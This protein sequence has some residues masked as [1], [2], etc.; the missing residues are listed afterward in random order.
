MSM[1]DTVVQFY[2]KFDYSTIFF[3][4]YVGS[5]PLCPYI[6]LSV[7]PPYFWLI[8]MCFYEAGQGQGQDRLV[9]GRLGTV[10]HVFSLR[11]VT[12]V[13]RYECSKRESCW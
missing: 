9:L 12:F 3:L 1:T 10:S 6:L 5:N 7:F 13:D 8:A 11:C 2:F 4:R